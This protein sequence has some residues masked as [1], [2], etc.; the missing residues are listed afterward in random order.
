MSEQANKSNYALKTKYEG[1]VLEFGSSIYVDNENITDEYGLIL[2]NRFLEL[3]T[4][5]ESIFTKFP[6]EYASELKEVKEPVVVKE[7]AKKAGKA[8]EV[9]EITA[10]AKEPVLVDKTEKATEDTTVSKPATIE[11]VKEDDDIIIVS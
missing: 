8:K 6:E 9:K 4:P 7:D 1:I 11:V 2:L 5:P 3:G 10:P